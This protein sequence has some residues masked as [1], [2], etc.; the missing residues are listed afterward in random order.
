MYSCFIYVNSIILTSGEPKYLAYLFAVYFCY[1]HS[2][3]LDPLVFYNFNF[4]LI[5]FDFISV[6]PE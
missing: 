3:W 2:H 5:H 4:V 6:N 1:S